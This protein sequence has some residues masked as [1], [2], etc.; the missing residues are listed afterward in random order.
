MSDRAD[1]FDVDLFV[2]GGGS[3]GVR[4]AR[5]A[6]GH[7]ARVAIAEADR[8]GGTCVIRGCVPKKLLVYA[9]RFADEFR[10]AAGYGWSIDSARFDWPTLI[11]NKDRE[12]ARLERLYAEGLEK[13][14]VRL[15][16][17]R[18]A[19]AGPQAVRLADGS[20]IR[21]AHILVATG[22]VPR[23]DPNW[24]AHPRVL[25]SDDMFRL[26]KLPA[27]LIVVGGGYIAVEFACLMHGLGVRTTLI[28]RGAELLRGFD[29]ELATALRQAM[30]ARGIE[31][32]LGARPTHIDGRADRVSLRLDDGRVLDADYALMAIGRDPATHGLG[33]EDVGVVLEANGAIAVDAASRSS[34]PS[35][36]AVGDVTDRVNLTPVAIREGQAFA[37]SVFGKREARVDHAL[38]PTAVFS[39]PELGCVGLTEAQALDEYAAIEIYRASFRP[40]KA[41]LGGSAERTLLKL[42]VDADSQRVLGAHMLGPDAAEMAQLLGIALR[43]N[44]RKADFDATMALHPTLAEEWVTLRA[45][46]RIT[47]G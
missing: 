28:H 43:M 21:A 30:Q 8:F 44:A 11:A 5:I 19:L 20:V 36:Y 32:L 24:A 34:V 39:T 23:R 4:A 47:R 18:A 37:D 42:I 27:R 10:D 15:Y 33:L 45:A 35:I 13:A 1:A 38:I 40:L 31:V 3:G 25:V 26:P 9:S 41:T 17:Q 46:Q 22:G 12:I 6:A 29:R 16:R 7:G 14:G 2:I